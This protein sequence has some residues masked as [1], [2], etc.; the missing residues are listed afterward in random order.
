MNSLRVADQP[1]GLRR[2]CLPS[3]KCNS[4]YF[5]LHWLYYQAFTAAAYALLIDDSA[6]TSS[7]L[8]WQT[9]VSSLIRDDFVVPDDYATLH[10]TV[11]DALSHR[12]GMPRH[13][14]SYGGDNYTLRDVVRGMRNLPLTAEIRTKFQY[15]NMMYMTMSHVIETLTSSWLGDFFWER[16]WKPLDMSRTYFTIQQAQAAVDHGFAELAT[17]YMW[18]NVTK[19]FMSLPYIDLTTVSGAG[20]IISNVLDYAK[21]L[22]FLIDDA[23]PLSKAGHEALR[24][25]RIYADLGE[26]P[27]FTG[28][29][30]YGLGWIL[31]NFHG[32]LLLLI[33]GDCQA[34]E[35]SLAIFP[36]SAGE[37]L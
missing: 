24:T 7:P 31:S 16:I 17:P 2:C 32:E 33:T 15:C 35:L 13:D 34:L 4:I 23:P 27:S 29:Q 30:N 12:T 21:W 10:A 6:N 25:S 36:G 3:S 11:E 9:T 37:W 19:E 22:Q 1:L 26:N 28:T 5:V 20:A 18:N 8:S 14:F